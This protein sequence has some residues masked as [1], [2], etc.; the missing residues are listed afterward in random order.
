MLRR[1][2]FESLIYRAYQL[3]DA[4]VRTLDGTSEP[5]ARDKLDN[6]SGGPGVRAWNHSSASRLW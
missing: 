2:G 6:G 3:T 4:L 5:L 1:T